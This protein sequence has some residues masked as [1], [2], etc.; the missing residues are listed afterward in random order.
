[1][2]WTGAPFE[3]ADDD[4]RIDDA[5]DVVDRP[6]AVEMHGAGLRVDLDFADVAAVGP[7]RRVDG[8]LRA[9]LDALVGLPRGELE[10]IDVPVGARDAEDAVAVLDVARRGFEL[11]RASSCAFATVRSDATRTADPTTKSEREPALPKPVPD[12]YHRRAR[13]CDRG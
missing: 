3:L 5:P 4:H 8:A 1:M 13:R 2:P 10:Q 6:V 11:L 7:A 12:R 9:E